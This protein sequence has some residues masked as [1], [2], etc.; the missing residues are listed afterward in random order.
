MKLKKKFIFVLLTATVSILIGYIILAKN[1]DV[2]LS[3]KPELLVL[4]EKLEKKY[5]QD[6][7]PI[8]IY[9]EVG[10][11]E[12]EIILLKN[13]L[14]QYPE[15]IAVEDVAWQKKSRSEDT[16]PVRLIPM[17]KR[18]PNGLEGYP[19]N[20]LDFLDES[21]TNPSNLTSIIN[22]WSLQ[23]E[24]NDFLDWP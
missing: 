11:S 4:E 18:D 8:Y 9:I 24:Q 2:W 3:Q 23:G 14:E 12:E 13:R 10:A 5:G 21:K 20:I 17:V 22:N 1:T 7:K 6:Y 19:S 16:A 15:V